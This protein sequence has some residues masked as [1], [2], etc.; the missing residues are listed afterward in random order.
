MIDDF[1]EKTCSASFF[2]EMEIGQNYLHSISVPPK[3]SIE[4]SITIPKIFRLNWCSRI[5]AKI[6]QG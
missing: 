2:F 1:F 3:P 5:F 6:I 4:V